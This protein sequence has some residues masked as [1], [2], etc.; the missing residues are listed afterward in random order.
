MQKEFNEN[1]QF[2]KMEDLCE[3]GF[4]VERDQHLESNIDPVVKFQELAKIMN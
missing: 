4:K 1:P 3:N 2:T